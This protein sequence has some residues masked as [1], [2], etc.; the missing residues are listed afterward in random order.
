MPDAIDTTVERVLSGADASPEAALRGL[1]SALEQEIAAR[2]A[3]LGAAE[4]AWVLGAEGGG[5]LGLARRFI[6]FYTAALRRELCDAEGGCLKQKYRDLIGSEDTKTQIK[7]VTPG[8]LEAL[9]A[10]KD[11][12]ASPV[13]IG[14][15][16][17]LWLVR[18]GLEQWCAAPSDT[19]TQSF[20]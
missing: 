10:D 7:Q 17:A 8:V 19:N 4:P 14:A 15:Y 6:A 3:V 20:G 9:G 16:V 12:F 13:T 11:R 1:D 2:A 18:S 5:P